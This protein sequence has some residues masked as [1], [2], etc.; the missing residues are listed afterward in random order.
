MN[1]DFL[2]ENK[3]NDIITEPNEIYKFKFK[4]NFDKCKF[5]FDF[6]DS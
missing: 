3:L 5:K 4:L 6:I 1:F 2:N